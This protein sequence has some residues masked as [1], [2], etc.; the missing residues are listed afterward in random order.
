MW[1]LQ[2][3]LVRVSGSVVQ[4]RSWELNLQSSGA[5]LDNKSAI[6]LCKNPVYLEWI[7]HID[8]LYHFIRECFE[9]EKLDV[10]HVGTDLQLADLL[11]KGLGHVKFIE[12]RQKLRVEEVKPVQQ[13]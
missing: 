13:A 10:D 12:M 1:Q 6:E 8:V 11:T 9:S 5:A 7:K 3:L 2:Q 4:G